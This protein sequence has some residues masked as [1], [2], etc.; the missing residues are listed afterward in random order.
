MTK[1][2]QAT[3]QA[4][5]A[6]A[7]LHSLLEPHHTV[8]DR[9]DGPFVV[10]TPDARWTHFVAGS[11]VAND[12]I[13]AP[14][15]EGLRV[16]P[17]GR[18]STTGEPAFTLSLAPEK[19]ENDPPGQFD[20]CKWLAYTTH[21]ASTGFPGFDAVRGQELAFETW[22]T[23]RTFGT[24][25]HPFGSAVQNG[26][27]D[28]RLAMFGQNTLDL[29]SCIIFN[30]MFTNERVYAIYE[31]LALMRTPQH[32]YAAFTYSIPV[33]QRTP[34]AMH[35]V[36]ITYDRAAGVVRWLLEDKEVFRVDRIGRRLDSR[37]LITDHGGQ[38]EDVEIRQLNGGMGMFT[39]LDA[40]QDGRGLVRLT[41][42][43]G[44]YVLPST[45][46][47]AGSGFVDE[48]SQLSHRVFGQGAEFR[49]RQFVISSTPILSASSSR[50]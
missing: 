43:P 29:E 47:A 3:Q 32:P 46:D 31:R 19:G 24:R 26:D 6:A 36:K 44:Y 8:W 45:Q 20:H 7:P 10:G 25:A 23:G 2:Q 22:I 12:G 38:E 34:E 48:K 18:N 39:L 37:W 35:H 11:F 33:A 16:V 13:A 30:Y 28:L 9:F 1:E 49:L 27:D 42:K 21:K 5:I 14:S 50:A 41:G 4:P 40:F 17:P 15:L